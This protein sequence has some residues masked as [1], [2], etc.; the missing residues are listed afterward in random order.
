MHPN[1]AFRQTPATQ[2]IAFAREAAFGLLCVGTETAP[3]ISHIPFLLS[4]DGALAEFHL[5][6]SNPIAR[7][8]RKGQ[9]ARAPRGAGAA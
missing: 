2:D 3:L 7:L 8:L 1:P 5:V 4:E 6:R 9:P